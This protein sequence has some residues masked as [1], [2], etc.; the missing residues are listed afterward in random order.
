[1]IRGG[2]HSARNTW[3]EIG[4]ADGK[5]LLFTVNVLYCKR[6]AFLDLYEGH[7]G[8]GLC[9]TFSRRAWTT[10]DLSS[11]GCSAFYRLCL[12]CIKKVLSELPFKK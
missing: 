4:N 5:R 10:A 1:V 2:G 6:A 11:P 8:A 9:V 12:R 3:K 7:L